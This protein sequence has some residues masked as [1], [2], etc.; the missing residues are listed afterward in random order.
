M[1]LHRWLIPVAAL[2]AVIPLA[3]HG[4]SC[5]KDFAFHLQSWL[6]A[7]EQLRHGVYP[8]WNFLSAYNAGEPRYLFYPPISWLLGGLLTLLL[9]FSWAP[10]AVSWIA[11]SGAGFS[12]RRLAIRWVPQPAALL[13]ACVY[14]A[15]PFLLFSIAARSAYGEIFAAAALPLLL[16][17]LLSAQPTVLALALPLAFIWLSNVPGGVIAAYLFFALASLRLLFIASRWRLILPLL[18]TYTGAGLLAIALDAFFL[19]PALQQRPFIHAGEPFLFPLRPTDSL[20]FSHILRPAAD[21]FLIRIGHLALALA[22]LTFL[23]LAVDWYLGR[24]SSRSLI[25]LVAAALA[26]VVCFLLTVPSAPLWRALPG[27]YILQFPWRLLMLLAISMALAV[28]VAMRRARLGTWATAVL[29]LAAVA[30][31]S[32][33][34]FQLYI[35]P[36][37]ADE[38][39]LATRTGL[40]V[41]HH[42]PEPTDEYVIANADQELMRPDNPP[43]WLARDPL[44]Y[45]PGTTPNLTETDT[46]APMPAV[47]E[48]ANL[49]ATPLHFTVRAPCDEFVIVNLQAYPNWRL[50]LDGHPADPGPTRPDGLLT[51][52]IDAGTTYIAIRWHHGWDEW[53]GSLI[54]AIA[55]ALTGW[56]AGRR[57]RRS[58]T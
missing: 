23:L 17:A 48:G 44:A 22:A 18:L 28:A 38:T 35:Q 40:L 36:C 31:L 50:L 39:P 5:G 53:T 32:T 54:T 46:Q 24:R 58:A 3:L 30:A 4:P 49:S 19:L 37:N 1:R 41:H 21:A 15:N 12:F 42:A 45:A 9:P 57:Y 7:A 55:L 43:F 10:V 14:L 8:R 16:E 52:P 51:I 25:A 13:S 29:S 2:V 33:L 26:A 56:L 6:D 47:P 34:A 20:F 11:L 27:L